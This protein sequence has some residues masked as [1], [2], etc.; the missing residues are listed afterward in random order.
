LTVIT[1]CAEE[2]VYRCE[3]EGARRGRRERSLKDI[4]EDQGDVAPD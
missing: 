2:R 1:L 3:R 4:G